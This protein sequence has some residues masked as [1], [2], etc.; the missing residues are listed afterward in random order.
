MPMRIN[1]PPL[2]RLVLGLLLAFSLL[3]GVIRYTQWAKK[4][5]HG[6][7]TLDTQPSAVLVPYLALVPQL[8]LF[9]PWV[10][11]TATLVEQN[12]FSLVV[13]LA[14]IFYGGRYLERAWGSVGLGRFL[15]V[16]ALT[17]NAI[18]FALYIVWYALTGNVSRS[19][20]TICGGVALQGGFLVAFKQLVPEHTVTIAKGVI[21]LRVKHFPAIFLLWNTLAGLI[22]GMDTSLMLA[23]LGFLTSWVYLRFYKFNPDLS[24]TSTGASSGIRGDPSETFAFAAFFP[25]PI[26]TPITAVS[27]RIYD[28]LVTL[29]ICTPFSA[30]DVEMGNGHALAR[31]EAGLP[32]LLNGGGRA[33]VRGG[34]GKREEAERRRAL[35][36][37]ALD[38]RLHAASSN[39]S[40][41]QS[42]PPPAP[43]MT[44]S[45]PAG[46]SRA[47]PE[48]NAA[49]S[50]SE[51]PD[52]NAMGKPDA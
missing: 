2:T 7:H 15:L 24:S 12:I 22:F 20:T 28:V 36:L 19:L 42:Q 38:Q 4:F 18:S 5:A 37:K 25:D 45:A 31:E 33:G 17:S 16:V 49:P 34:G 46:P 41:S 6:K 1:I 51:A 52:H 29:R 21:K 35:A 27:D 10:F 39:K 40:Q 11:L 13:T 3:N 32:S 47:P 8:S 44:A 43:A 50:A 14:T 9:Y 26:S 30:E 23:W 48:T